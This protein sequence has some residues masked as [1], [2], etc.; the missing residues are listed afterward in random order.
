M[1]PEA[2]SYDEAGPLVYTGMSVLDVLLHA[3]LCL[4]FVRRDI[5]INGQLYLRRWYLRGRGTASQWFLHN[6]RLP[7][8]GREM[9]DHPWDF[10]TRILAGGYTEDVDGSGEHERPA[11]TLLDN[12]AEHTHRL[13]AV[14]P[15]TWTLVHA[16]KA[17]RVWGFLREDR[18]TWEP[19][20][21]YLG[22]PDAMDWP[23]DALTDS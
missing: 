6:I 5:V 14:Q 23:E 2:K 12:T 8:A 17:R 19:W 10:K 15:G 9:H 21:E 7:D 22:T 13:A 11:G 1:Q 20:R 18:F 3:L 4:L 16:G